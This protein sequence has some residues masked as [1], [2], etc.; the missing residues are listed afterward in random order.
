MKVYKQNTEPLEFLLS[1]YKDD[2]NKIV[3]IINNARKKAFVKINEE[4]INL[5]WNIGKIICEKVE[6]AHWGA[7]VVDELANFI[8]EKNPD[9][10][11]FNRRGLFR[12]KKFYETYKEN[13]KV[14]TLLTQIPW[15]V[16]LHILSK[17]ARISSNF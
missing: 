7:G 10:K 5:Y 14:S 11:G 2:F 1:K 8:K 15:S 13:E 12:M 9:I 3:Q 17:T 4:L 6:N 16:H